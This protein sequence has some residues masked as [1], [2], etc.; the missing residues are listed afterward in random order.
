MQAVEEVRQVPGVVAEAE[1][2]QPQLPVQGL[3]A[4]QWASAP[5]LVLGP[6]QGEARVLEREAQER[7]QVLALEPVQVLAKEAAE[8]EV[9]AQ[10]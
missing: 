2:G 7:A 1:A 5:A 6:E 4:A 10:V 9:V 8:V 3:V